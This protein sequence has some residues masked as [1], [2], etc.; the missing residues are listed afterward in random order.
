MRT[1]YCPVI[2]AS[3]FQLIQQILS[4]EVITYIAS[5]TSLTSKQSK[6]VRNVRCPPQCSFFTDYMVNRDRS[7]WRNAVNLAI[8]IF[9][10]H[11]IPNNHNFTISCLILD[12]FLHNI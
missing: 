6:I 8:I 12:H 3:F 2:N 5:Q 4:M 7:F 9:I 1:L 11:N 10:Q